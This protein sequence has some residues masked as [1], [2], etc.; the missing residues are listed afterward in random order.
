M[1][2]LTVIGIGNILMSDEGVGVR[3]VEK[4]RD[5]AT[6]P[7]QIE[8]VDG[9]AGG[10]NLLNII[11]GADRLIVFDAADMRLP[12]GQFRVISPDQVTEPSPDHYVSMHD[13]P[14]MET[15][16]LCERF[17]HC[18]EPIRI[19]AIQPETIDFGRQLSDRLGDA[20]PGLLDAA[21]DLVRRE[22]AEAGIEM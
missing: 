7:N 8:F 11:E 14:L 4:L 3:L 21:G 22:A 18:P 15:L 1:A 9:G 10:L 19:M 20:F 2:K 13:V 6:W 16:S 12:P 5:L 17:S